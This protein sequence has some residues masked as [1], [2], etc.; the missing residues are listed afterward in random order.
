MDALKADATIEE[1]LA[2]LDECDKH[3]YYEGYCVAD[4]HKIFDAIANP[5]DW[6]A[7][8]SCVCG[9]E[10]VM[11]TVSAIKFYTASIP[12]VSLDVTTMRYYIT[13][14][15]YRNGPAGDH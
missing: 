1:T 8:I 12:K 15:G 4:L 6:K 13:A 14:D 3:D 5:S 10:M 11:P 9:G 2:Y 7:P